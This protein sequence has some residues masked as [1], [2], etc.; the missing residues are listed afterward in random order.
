MLPYRFTGKELDRETG[1]YYYGARYLNPKSSRWVSGDPAGWELINPNREGFSFVESQNWYSYTSNNPVKYVD[2]TGMEGED[3]NEEEV[4]WFLFENAVSQ[5]N[6][7]ID[8][9]TDKDK[10]YVDKALE[11][12]KINFTFWEKNKDKLIEEHNKMVDESEKI[13]ETPWKPENLPSPDEQ[14]PP[15]LGGKI[16]K[17]IGKLLEIFGSD[18]PPPMSE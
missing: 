14:T 10:K 11:S 15:T 1:L 5:I 16:L 7:H 18:G 2:P 12:W 13:T 8:N 6:E 4:G 9:I 17:G 3:S